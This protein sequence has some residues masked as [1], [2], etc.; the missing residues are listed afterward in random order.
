LARPKSNT[1]AYPSWDIMRFEGLRSRCT[2][3][4]P[5]AARALGKQHEMLPVPER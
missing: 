5:C 3:P 4:A 2:M 1:F